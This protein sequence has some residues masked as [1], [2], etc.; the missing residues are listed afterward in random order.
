MV[1]PV[2]SRNYVTNNNIK[3]IEFHLKKGKSYEW[4][5]KNLRVGKSTIA[6]VKRNMKAQPPE[7]I[8]SKE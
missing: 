7:Q 3:L 8:N 6:G 1:K 5:V 4:I 2:G